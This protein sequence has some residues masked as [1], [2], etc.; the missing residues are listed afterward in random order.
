MISFRYVD[1][2]SIQDEVIGV[3]NNQ[4]KPVK[5]MNMSNIMMLGNYQSEISKIVNDLVMP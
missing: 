4:V 3:I 1:D 2:V 5:V